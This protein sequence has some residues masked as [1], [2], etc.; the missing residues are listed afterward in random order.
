M[1]NNII[2]PSSSDSYDLERTIKLI[3]NDS[4]NR[5]TKGIP[6][7][8]QQLRNRSLSKSMLQGGLTLTSFDRPRSRSDV[9]NDNIATLRKTISNTPSCYPV[10]INNNNNNGYGR[11]VDDNYHD[12][13]DDDD[14][15]MMA[16]P[17][18][19]LKM[20]STI[21]ITDGTDYKRDKSSNN[22]HNNS[23]SSNY[24]QQNG[25]LDL[26]K[27]FNDF[28][29]INKQRHDDFKYINSLNNEKDSYFSFCSNINT[30]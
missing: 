19:R 11:I 30:L 5:T 7:T 29:A 13:D 21:G 26:K 14:D 23:S 24:C 20:S 22:L 12:G 3:K 27:D 8:R 15:D 10:S 1:N 9:I 18:S 16:V 6:A 28:K 2:A 17:K 25:G 4:F